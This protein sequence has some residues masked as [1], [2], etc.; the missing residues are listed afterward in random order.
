[1][2]QVKDTATLL[3]LCVTAFHRDVVGCGE[4]CEFGSPQAC[5]DSPLMPQACT[6]YES[7]VQTV[8]PDVQD[9]R[10]ATTLGVTERRPSA[11]LESSLGQ[12]REIT[13]YAI[14]L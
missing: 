1:M 6:P 13:G 7:G 9:P 2:P 10:C 3:E 12:S 14:I 11:D 8:C 5:L 4:V